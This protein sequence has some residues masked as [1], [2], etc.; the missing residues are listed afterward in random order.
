MLSGVSC[1]DAS[2]F[3]MSSSALNSLTPVASNLLWDGT[4]MWIFQNEIWDHPIS[5]FL[6]SFYLV[7][8]L[9][10]VFFFF[11]HNGFQLDGY[12]SVW[13]LLWHGT[14]CSGVNV[15]ARLVMACSQT[16]WEGGH[17]A[18]RTESHRHRMASTHTHNQIR[19]FKRLTLIHT[20]HLDAMPNILAEKRGFIVNMRALAGTLGSLRSAQSLF[21]KSEKEKDVHLTNS[22]LL[23]IALPFHL[24]SDS[25]PTSHPRRAQEKCDETPMSFLV[26]MTATHTRILLTSLFLLSKP[27]RSRWCD[28]SWSV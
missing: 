23:K 9:Y 19:L 5:A 17:T 4:V 10:A 20:P 14:W 11:F 2:V 24:S 18:G 1:R 13:V 12:Y 25:F 21:L 3:Q 26:T 22:R 8:L 7:V 28:A 6:F 16:G 27:K 15:K